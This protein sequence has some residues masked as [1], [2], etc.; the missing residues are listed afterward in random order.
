MTA[1]KN[2]LGALTALKDR[3]GALGEFIQSHLYFLLA[4]AVIVVIALG[5]FS[6]YTSSIAPGLQSRD[7]LTSQLNDARKALAEARK[8]APDDAP[9]L[10]TRIADAQ[11]TLTTSLQVFV[12]DAQVSQILDALYQYASA[13]NVVITDLQTQT[14]PGQGAKDFYRVTTVRMQVRGPS[15]RLVNFVSRIKEASTKGMVISNVGIAWGEKT[16]TAVLNMDISLYVLSSSGALV[17]GPP[18]A[19]TLA[20][21]PQPQVTP[22]TQP[23]ATPTLSVEQ[24]AQRLD[25]LWATGDWVQVIALLEQI[26]MID[27][28]Y[29]NLQEKLYAAYVIYGYQ[30]LSTGRTEEA[31]VMFSRAVGIKPGGEAAAVLSQL[32]GTPTSVVAPTYVAPTLAPPTAIPSPTPRY[33]IYTVRAGDTLS[34]IA[35]RYGVTVEAIMAANGLTNYTIRVG[36]QLKIPVP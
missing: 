20:A 28:N 26:R 8:I 35:R 7:K 10:Q 13:S 30:L 6:F 33:V 17:V 15:D 23:F 27:P 34:A 36:Q 1:L 24:L 18:A 25:A 9:A 5:Y 21:T 22:V 2:R 31:K 19:G 29:G 3:L 16:P 14:A 4:A 11:A 12:T 32:S